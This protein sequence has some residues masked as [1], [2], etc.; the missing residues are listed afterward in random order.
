MPHITKTY[1]TECAT[2]QSQHAQAVTRALRM[3]GWKE[4]YVGQAPD[5]K[6]LTFRPS[7]SQD[8]RDGLQRALHYAREVEREASGIRQLIQAYV[9]QEG[10]A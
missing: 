8:R 7:S 9:E 6:S 3:A 10:L 4:R 2:R 1:V 5:H